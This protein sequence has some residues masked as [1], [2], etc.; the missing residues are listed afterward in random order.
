VVCS[1][2]SVGINTLTRAIREQDLT[3]AEAIGQAL[4]AGSNCGSCIP[5]LKALL[6]EVE[7][8]KVS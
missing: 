6:K 7:L 2:F 3:T 8:S 1:C 4:K 5:E